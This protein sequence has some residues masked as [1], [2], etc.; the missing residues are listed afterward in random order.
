ML[1]KQNIGIFFFIIRNFIFVENINTLKSFHEVGHSFRKKSFVVKNENQ[2]A[3]HIAQLYSLISFWK[4][5]LQQ[6]SSFVL[7]LG[8]FRSDPMYFNFTT[9]LVLIERI[10]SSESY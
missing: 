9:V 1:C 5:R 2:L 7:Y 6:L 10:F 8:S 4:L 3:S